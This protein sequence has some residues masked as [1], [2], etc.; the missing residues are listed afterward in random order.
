[1]AHDVFISYSERDKTVAD[2][3]CATLEGRKIR[4]WIAPRDVGPGTWAGALI[5]AIRESRVFVLIFSDGS[6]RSPQVLREVAEA[7]SSGIPIIPF[8]IEDVQL[9][10]DMQ[11]YIKTIH[12]L[13]AFTPPLERHLKKL[14]GWIEALLAV[15]D[16]RLPLVPHE[17]P[18]AEE[19]SDPEETRGWPA[20]WRVWPTWASAVVLVT[21]LTLAVVGASQLLKNLWNP[22]PEQ[23][24]VGG[25]VATPA[26]S[27]TPIDTPTPRSTS[28]AT[29]SAT[30]TPT[31]TNTPA[32][33]ATLTSTPTATPK[34]PTPT[35]TVTPTSTGTRIPT[36]T[37]MPTV[38]PQPTA[39]W[40]QTPPDTPTVT[41]SP[42]R[43]G[44]LTP[45]ATSA[46]TP[47]PSRTPTPTAPPTPTPSRTLTPTAPPTPTPT[48]T[49]TPT[50]PP[51]PTP[52]H[53]PTPT[54]S[55]TPTPSH[56]LTATHTPVPTAAPTATPLAAP[57]LL[58]PA[59]GSQFN[60]E[61]AVIILSWTSVE[62]LGPDQYYVVIS[63]YPH[64]G[65]TWHDWQWTKETEL[66]FPDYL[67]D[68]LTS[69]RQVKWWVVVMRPISE[70]PPQDSREGQQVGQP[71]EVRT[72]TWHSTRPT[73][74]RL[75]T[76]TRVH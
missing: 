33:T 48:R 58:D 1:M 73:P 43:T 9:S 46:P 50:A 75:A 64:N 70:P 28:A 12:W 19:V 61:G 41:P 65:A 74:T 37:A 8:R 54:T 23:T 7:V 18:I 59:D 56:T 22:K 13:D 25:P 24:E 66:E 68:L 49:L 39:T 62:G 53:T 32:P 20:P 52:S 26:T 76:P 40:T 36:R 16:E 5:D 67:Y 35:P 55:L 71:S 21:L 27:L 10:K 63:E 51:T 31:P 30:P 34:P 44:T 4:C 57:T 14:V 42:T 45:T 3:M 38:T 69:P 15:E 60:G 29:T 11:Y 2:A 17:A 72:F 47:T 6:N